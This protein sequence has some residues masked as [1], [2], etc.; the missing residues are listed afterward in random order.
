M[1][2]GNSKV[3]YNLRY[4][5]L[6]T[7]LLIIAKPVFSKTVYVHERWRDGPDKNARGQ[8]YKGFKPLDYF[9]VPNDTNLTSRFYEDKFALED[10][11]DYEMP[12]ELYSGVRTDIAVEDYYLQL[13]QNSGGAPSGYFT[14]KTRGPANQQSVTEGIPRENLRLENFDPNAT[15]VKDLHPYVSIRNVAGLIYRNDTFSC[16]TSVVHPRYESDPSSGLSIESRK[17]DGDLDLTDGADDKICFFLYLPQVKLTNGLSLGPFVGRVQVSDSVDPINNQTEPKHVHS[18]ELIKNGLAPFLPIKKELQERLVNDT[19]KIRYRL[20][21]YLI[22]QLEGHLILPHNGANVLYSRRQADRLYHHER[23][24]VKVTKSKSSPIFLAILVGVFTLGVGGLIAGAITVAVV[25]SAIGVGVITALLLPG[26]ESSRILTET[27]S[28]S[29][30][31]FASPHPNKI[32]AYLA[33]Q[34]SNNTENADY[35]SGAKPKFFPVRPLF[36]PDDGERN[37]LIQARSGTISTLTAAGG[38]SVEK[39]VNF[40][41]L[42]TQGSALPDVNQEIKDNEWKT[43][44]FP[45]PRWYQIMKGP[46]YNHAPPPSSVGN[47]ATGTLKPCAQATD[48]QVLE[49]CDNNKDL[50]EDLGA[51]IENYGQADLVTLLCQQDSEFIEVG[52]RKFESSKALKDLADLYKQKET[53]LDQLRSA[54]TSSQGGVEAVNSTIGRYSQTTEGNELLS[55]LKSIEDS[56]KSAS[57]SCLAKRWFI[58]N[59]SEK[60]RLITEINARYSDC[61]NM[62]EEQKDTCFENRFGT[63][64]QGLLADYYAIENFAPIQLPFACFN[65][66][67]FDEDDTKDGKTVLGILAHLEG[68]IGPGPSIEKPYEDFLSPDEKCSGPPE[69][70]TLSDRVECVRAKITNL[71][72]GNTP[73]NLKLRW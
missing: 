23:H 12:E 32:F 8:S 3:Q 46:G 53:E 38:P 57:G 60:N 28:G 51:Y 56:L 6:V 18:I 5:F 67:C 26:D 35:Q 61:T 48:A 58:E 24:E 25:G 20:G 34:S 54:L 19:Y 30:G 13:M 31:D 68:V 65:A 73:I 59:Q 9:M 21:R 55:N 33:L 15:D 72:R 71:E 29:K 49:L 50:S 39:K 2:M 43:K 63:D 14:Y 22:P 27:S 16:G 45:D 70:P 47:P 7:V 66:A 36:L 1:E 64:P 42:D 37:M 10:H 62:P 69:N 40:G 52:T 17:S 44:V 41:Y 4:L 11:S